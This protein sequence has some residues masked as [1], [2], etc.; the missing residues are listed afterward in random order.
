MQ[1]KVPIDPKTNQ[2]H[3]RLLTIPF[4]TYTT[5]NNHILPEKPDFES[6]ISVWNIRT[7]EDANFERSLSYFI[8]MINSIPG[9][10]EDRVT[11][12]CKFQ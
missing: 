4:I 12:E 5:N 10:S 3:S 6:Q 8:C 2:E 1:L 9:L 11:N 7:I